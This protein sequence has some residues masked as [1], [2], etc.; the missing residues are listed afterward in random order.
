MS[1]YLQFGHNDFDPDNGEEPEHLLITLGSE[2]L[3]L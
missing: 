2:P 1:G 3:S